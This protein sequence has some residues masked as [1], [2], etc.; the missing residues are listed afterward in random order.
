MVRLIERGGLEDFASFHMA[1]HW[2]ADGTQMT[3]AIRRA[4]GGSVPVR[5]LP[6]LLMRLATPFVPLL[7]E[8]VEMKYLWDQPVRLRN[9]KL[10]AVLGSEPRT[11]LDTAVRATLAAMGCL[12]G[13]VA[14]R[15]AQARSVAL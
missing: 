1:G 8:L 14:G 10:E 9:G 12:D 15:Q 6:W 13:A 2:D 5:R 4:L 7:R 11:P 3:G